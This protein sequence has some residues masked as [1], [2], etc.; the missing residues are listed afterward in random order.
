MVPCGI[1][2]QR[3]FFSCFCLF[4]DRSYREGLQLVRAVP[5]TPHTCKGL[6]F[7]VLHDVSW[8]KKRGSLCVLVEI[9]AKLEHRRQCL[10]AVCGLDWRQSVRST[11]KRSR[12]KKKKEKDYNEDRDRG[13]FA[14]EDLDNSEFSADKGCVFT[15]VVCQRYVA[16]VIR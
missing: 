15:L 9:K 6:H 7:L 13:C 8:S 1:I 14:G 10:V 11:D 2:Y 16:C 12:H 3:N 4:N 5:P